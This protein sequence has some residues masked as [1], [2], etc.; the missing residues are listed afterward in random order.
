MKA[1]ELIKE[2]IKVAW[3][4][5][6][7][8]ARKGEGL[9]WPVLVGPS[10]VGKTS[11]LE[12]LYEGP[13]IKILLQTER[14]EDVLGIPRVERGFTRWF[15][16]ERWKIAFEKPCLIFFD[17]LDKADRETV[18]A[19]LTLM[20]N[21]EVNGRKLHPE[22][23]IACA[24]QP[25]EYHWTRHQTNKALAGRACFI[26]FEPSIGKAWIAENKGVNLDFLVLEDERVDL[27]SIKP[28]VRQI[29]W[30]IE[31]VKMFPELDSDVL[32]LLASGIGLTEEAKKN[33]LEAVQASNPGLRLNKL[34]QNPEMLT[35]WIEQATLAELITPAACYAAVITEDIGPFVKLLERCLTEGSEDDLG[36]FSESLASAV[37]QV[38][39]EQGGG[40]SVVIWSKTRDSAEEL[41]D[42]ISRVEAILPKVKEARKNVQ[43]S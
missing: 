14:P 16:H 43:N 29:N 8:L 7:S 6:A 30:F 10:G 37:A 11:T 31:L 5:S 1:T 24:M 34:A 39:R 12:A 23:V 36:V 19:V 33:L 4:V 38:W 20:N 41:D 22:T 28:T 17:E 9:V 42:L 21:L 32:S 13:I 2:A 27:P 15:L 35:R 3:R 26:P 40:D 18:S 25:V